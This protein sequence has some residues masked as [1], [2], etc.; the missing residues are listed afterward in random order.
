M[1]KCHKCL[2]PTQN[3]TFANDTYGAPKS[4]DRNTLWKQRGQATLSSCSAA[5]HYI[6]VNLILT[7]IFFFLTL[8]TSGWATEMDMRTI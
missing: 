7:V 8:I 2:S 3:R 6:E 4:G 1:D 5:G